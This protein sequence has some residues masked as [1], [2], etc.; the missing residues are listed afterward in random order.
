[1]IAFEI[2][3]NG[4]KFVVAGI[5]D[6]DL[7]H[8]DI[9]AR[10]EADDDGGNIYD[11]KVGGLPIQTEEGKLEHVRWPE[12]ELKVG[13]EITIR[14]VETDSADKPIKRYRSDKTVQENPF[15]EEEM[16]EFQKQDYLRLKELFKNED[17]A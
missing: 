17:F 16:R 4:K 14:I 15:T 3:V 10:R 13:D 8:T 11:L 2:T 6:W 1:M 5:E 12:A 9:M 7:L